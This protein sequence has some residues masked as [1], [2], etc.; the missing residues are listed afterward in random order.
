[1]AIPLGIGGALIGGLIGS[2]M[3]GPVTGFDYRSLLLAIIGMLGTL[4]SAAI[5]SLPLLLVAAVIGGGGTGL[6]Y[7]GS[8]SLVNLLIPKEQRGG[9]VQ[10]DILLPA[11]HFADEFNA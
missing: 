7:L 1:M 5:G 6:A 3:G 2:M 4:Y 11:A 10:E 8:L 9:V